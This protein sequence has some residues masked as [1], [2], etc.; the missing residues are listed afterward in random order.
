[1]T[2]A[3]ATLLALLLPLL[4][5]CDRLDLGGDKARQVDRALERA[6]KLLEMRDFAGAAVAY[7]DV[8]R[9]DAS[10]ADAYF[11]AAL[12][13][14]RNLND[15]LNAAYNYQRYLNAPGTDSKKTDLVKSCLNNT[16]LRLAASIPNAGN[17]NSPELVKLRTEN[18]ALY[19]Q[20]EDLK[21]EMVRVRSRPE[22]AK[23]AAQPARPAPAIAPPPAKP[24]PAASAKPR[25][26]TV[27]RGEGIQTISEKVYGN[28]TRWRDI[29]SANPSLKDPTHLKVGQ[30]LVIPP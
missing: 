30:V 6:R 22:P 10:H 20:V 12:I 15:C 8:L 26:Y 2:R 3:V 4:A 24:K 7:E 19:R 18:A 16:L 13:Y 9:V 11:Q 17:Q 23:P 28:R 14:D 1:M 29:M 5:G 27:Q 25:S 21:R